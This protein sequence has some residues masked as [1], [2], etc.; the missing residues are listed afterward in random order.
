MHSRTRGRKEIHKRGEMSRQRRSLRHGGSSRWQQQVNP[1]DDPPICHFQL[2]WRR[3]GHCQQ[4]SRS[5]L[6]L[7]HIQVETS[8]FGPETKLM[9]AKFTTESRILI[10]RPLQSKTVWIRSK[11]KDGS[12]CSQDAAGQLTLRQSVSQ[13]VRLSS[14]RQ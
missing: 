12:P 3:G 2:E 5:W 7:D 10:P 13:S 4:R 8:R 14:S 1:N 11:I 9:K 6:Y